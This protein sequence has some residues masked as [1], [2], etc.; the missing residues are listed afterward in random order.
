MKSRLLE[1]IRTELRTRL[2][3]LTKAAY[4][5]HAAATDPGSKAESKYDTRNLEASYLA[6][7]Q[8]RQVEELAEAVRIFDALELPDFQPQDAVEAGALVETRLH[9]ETAHFLLVPSSGGLEISCDGKEVTLLTPDSA[10]YRKLAGLVVGDSL[11]M[12]ALT[13]VAVS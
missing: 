4:E 10:L 6:V 1:H 3:R 12:P 11:E 9:G 13:V 8:S 2:D 7:G 5:A